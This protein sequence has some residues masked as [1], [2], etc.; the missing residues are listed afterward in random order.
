MCKRDCMIENK[1][2]AVSNAKL[3]PRYFMLIVDASLASAG[4]RS[5][6]NNKKW[7]FIVANSCTQAH[8]WNSWPVEPVLGRYKRAPF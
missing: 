7:Q 8:I 6:N 1:L 3:E 5:V 2:T 4:A